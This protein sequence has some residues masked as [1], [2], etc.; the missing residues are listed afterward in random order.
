MVRI[1]DYVQFKVAKPIPCGNRGRADEEADG[2]ILF[3]L[4]KNYGNRL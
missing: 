1:L 4:G 2:V 3:W